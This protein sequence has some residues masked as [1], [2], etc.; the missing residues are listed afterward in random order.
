[1][2]ALYV[3]LAISVLLLPLAWSCSKDGEKDDENT[4]TG[5]D[6]D[7]DTDVDVDTVLDRGSNDLSYMLGHCEQP[8]EGHVPVRE[9]FVAADGAGDFTTIQACVDQAQPGD[10][11]L[12]QPGDYGRVQILEGGTPD[13]Y[14]VIKGASAPDASHLETD[15]L[16]DPESPVQLP[17]NPAVNAVTRGFSIEASYVRVENFEVT[18]VYREGE[19]FPGRGAIYL[20]GCEHVEVVSNLIHD[21]NAETDSYNYQ[22]IRGDTHDTSH[23]LVKGNTLLRNQ[24]TGISLFG[25]NWTVAC[26]DISHTLD[27][28]TDTGAHVGGDSDAIRFFGSNHVIRHNYI[29]DLLDEE[30]AGEPHIDA[31]QVFTVHPESQFA[32]DILIEGNYMYDSGQMLMAEDQSESEG[33][34]NALYNITFVNNVFRKT[35]AVAIIVGTATDHFT[36]ANNVVT[37]AYYSGISI[38]TFSHHATVIN[39]IFYNNGQSQRDQPNGQTLSE[40]SAKEGSVWD[41]NMHYPDFSYPPKEP[42]FDVNGMYGIDPMFMD[43]EHEDYRIIGSSPAC[44][45]GSEGADIGAFPCVR[46]ADTTPIPYMVTTRRSGWEP[47]A[48]DFDASYSLICGDA[49]ESYQWD[50]GDGAQASGVTVSH[51]FGPGD[52]DVTLTVTNNHGMGASVS[53]RVSVEPS[54]LPNL[55]L[56]LSLDG[57]TDDWSGKGNQVTWEDGDAHYDI[58][59]SGQAGVFDGTEEG[60]YVMV[61]HQYFL[62]DIDQLSIALWAQKSGPAEEN[63]V[64]LKH[65]SY[66]MRL[67][68][69]GF[70]ADVYNQDEEVSVSATALQ[71]NDTNWHLYV[72]TYD[73]S[74]VRLYLDAVVVGESPFSGRVA[75]NVD[76]AVYLGAD[77]WGENFSGRLDEVRIYDKALSETEI[78]ALFDAP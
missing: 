37:E 40:E 13:N 69:D 24:G 73:G 3:L 35:R 70:R 75:R 39:N 22:G 5:S 9:L 68:A 66:S 78:Q 19:P 61:A 21:A 31:F 45:A 38:G 71:N 18:A 50:F 55:V 10:L 46:C 33:G 11:C 30:Q 43:F 60:P 6:A 23:I 56:G 26:N 15:D 58:G 77:P 76:R 65:T 44:G 53:K 74:A 16:Y 20:T 28:N 42:E 54:V 64:V 14:V 57:H 25:T 17:G 27:T 34:E 59:V 29:H 36:F 49:M 1:M 12:V 62:D 72:M 4:E 63:L 47:L 32:H 41:Y 67:F 51:T 8:D 52:V 2:K 7:T 48:V